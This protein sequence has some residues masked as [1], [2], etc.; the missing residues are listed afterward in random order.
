V[1]IERDLIIRRMVLGVVLVGTCAFWIGGVWYARFLFNDPTNDWWFDE[2]IWRANSGTGDPDN[3]RTKMVY[4]LTHR[5]LQKGMSRKQVFQILGKP[6][7]TFSN[8]MFLYDI[9][10]WGIFN[11]DGDVLEVDFDGRGRVVDAYKRSN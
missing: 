2:R 8:D 9:G 11:L 5:V 1:N 3:P 10:A 4:D 7:N 6:D